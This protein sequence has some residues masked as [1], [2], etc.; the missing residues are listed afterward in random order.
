M[1]HFCIAMGAAA[2]IEVN[3]SYVWQ[4]AGRPRA[5]QRTGAAPMR[6]QR[7]GLISRKTLAG[8][9]GSSPAM[10]VSRDLNEQRLMAGD[11]PMATGG[12]D[13]ADGGE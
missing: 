11:S 1:V 3:R 7:E 9:P 8:P 4:G 10:V 2:L 5:P 6:L 12:L 13:V